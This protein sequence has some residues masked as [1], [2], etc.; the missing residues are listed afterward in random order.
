[1]L[2]PKDNRS[3]AKDI[4]QGCPEDAPKLRQSSTKDIPKW[5][6]SCFSVAPRCHCGQANPDLARQAVLGAWKAVLSK[7]EAV[8]DA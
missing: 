6:P 3:G 2:A 4:L 5:H 1:M 8:L 7:Q